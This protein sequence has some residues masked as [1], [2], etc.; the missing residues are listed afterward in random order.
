MAYL[1]GA[2]AINPPEVGEPLE[3]EIRNRKT[4]ATIV[5]RPFY[6]RDE[7]HAASTARV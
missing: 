3:V 7:G 4:R 1:A 6:R 2:G 5:R